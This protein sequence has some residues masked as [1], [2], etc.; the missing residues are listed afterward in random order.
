[1]LFFLKISVLHVSFYL[2]SNICNHK[3]NINIF[4]DIVNKSL[5]YDLN[6]IYILKQKLKIIFVKKI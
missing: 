5:L 3:L 6:L 1:M 4:T 2:F